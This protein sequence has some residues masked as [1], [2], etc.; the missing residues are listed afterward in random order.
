MQWRLSIAISSSEKDV[1][2]FFRAPKRLRICFK[3]IVTPREIR[4]LLVFISYVW[5]SCVIFFFFL[6]FPFHCITK[7]VVVIVLKYIC[8]Q[9]R[10]VAG[11]KRRIIKRRKRKK[12][13]FPFSLKASRRKKKKK[14]GKKNYLILRRKT[15]TIDFNPLPTLFQ[16]R[17]HLSGREKIFF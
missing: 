10:E 8:R 2:V 5:F 13:R 16:L 12:Q 14:K 7:V 3:E 11:K 9:K 17:K 15:K 1:A 6:L 4:R